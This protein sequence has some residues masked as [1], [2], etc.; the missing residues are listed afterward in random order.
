MKK[1]N[2]ALAQ[3]GILKSIALVMLV[4]VATFGVALSVESFTTHSEIVGSKCV[5]G[6]I[7]A[8]DIGGKNSPGG[9]ENSLTSIYKIGGKGVKGTGGDISVS[10]IGGRGTNPTGEYSFCNIGGRS[11]APSYGC[12]F[13]VIGGKNPST[14]QYT[15]CFD[16]LNSEPNLIVIEN[17]ARFLSNC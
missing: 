2:S 8:S 11:Q 7:A 3:N 12:S 4:L 17:K 16:E 1:L 14:G 9:L 10:D 5:K 6:E 15:V 13:C